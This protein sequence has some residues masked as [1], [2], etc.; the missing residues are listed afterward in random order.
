MKKFINILFFLIATFG[1]YINVEATTFN[2]GDLIDVGE[3][4]TVDTELFTYKNF[5]YSYKYDAKG[6]G[7]I[8]FESI[9]NK[10]SDKHPVSIN[11]LLFNKKK[12]NIG[13]LSYCSELDYSSDF[14]GLVLKPNESTSYSINVTKRYF[15]T[16]D[17]KLKDNE[18]IK[19]SD[20]H[21]ISVL[22]DNEYC[23]VGGPTKYKGL[24][25]SEIMSGE[26]NT[27]AKERSDF[28][29]LTLSAL[30][31]LNTWK[32]LIIY[33]IVFFVL[34][35]IQGAII[36]A[37]YMRMYVKTSFLAYLPIGSNYLSVKLAFGD[38]VA[39]IYIISFLVSIP[40]SFIVIG[41][42]LMGILGLVSSFAFIIVIIKLI[43]K[44]YDMLMI[45]P[46]TKM[47]SLSNNYNV[48]SIDNSNS[49]FSFNNVNANNNGFNNINNSE[50]NNTNTYSNSSMNNNLEEESLD[51]SY[52]SANLFESNTNN[53]NN[54]SNNEGSDLTNLFK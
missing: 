51:L 2:E 42:V 18:I 43:T 30:K 41:Y 22:D 45:I 32:V 7:V 15:H 35:I 26:T 10:D 44:K 38:L 3:L 46:T 4:A 11:I 12:K 24:T 27:S 20:V 34:I 53:N 25:I 33:G 21:Y 23:K 16:D 28:Y 52:Q 47:N 37:L 31:D 13:F 54:N 48:S 1:F 8:D 5:K 49:N 29:E 40:L 39:K 19:G 9:I 6:N 17:E 50:V 14:S 36:N